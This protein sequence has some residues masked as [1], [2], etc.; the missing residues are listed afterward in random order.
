M[1]SSAWKSELISGYEAVEATDDDDP[2][3]CAPAEGPTNLTER[4]SASQIAVS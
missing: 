2:P 1:E 3:A 4:L